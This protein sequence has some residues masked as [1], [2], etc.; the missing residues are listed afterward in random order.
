M[1]RMRSCCDLMMETIDQEFLVEQRIAEDFAYSVCSG[2]DW[3]TV[4]LEP[5]LQLRTLLIETGT[6]LLTALSHKPSSTTV[7]HALVF[8]IRCYNSV[9]DNP[10]GVPETIVS[11]GVIEA[12][13][14]VLEHV[15]Q[16]FTTD[17]SEVTDIRKQLNTDLIKILCR[18]TQQICGLS[19]TLLISTVSS[20]PHS[21]LHRVS[22]ISFMQI[23]ICVTNGT[24]NR[25]ITSSSPAAQVR[26]CEFSQLEM[27]SCILDSLGT[28]LQVTKR[29]DLVASPF[30]QSLCHWMLRMATPELVDSDTVLSGAETA[31][32]MTIMALHMPRQQLPL[33]SSLLSMF[34][35]MSS[36]VHILGRQQVVGFLAA[37]AK[38]T[39]Y[40]MNSAL[41]LI[42]TEIKQGLWDNM[43]SM[44]QASCL[45]NT[46]DLLILHNR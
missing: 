10:V 24:H 46:L 29:G 35:Q 21:F 27:H 17:L 31:R 37:A 9:W 32:I 16:T 23:S 20:L 34:A 25:A 15:L 28:M 22:A 43:D 30:M 12:L 44:A 42:G 7:H 45:F 26:S 14:S 6:R 18:F 2:Q 11:G 8:A 36:Q 38:N 3:R 40:N 33:P 13:N 4:P 1:K 41:L 39:R 5:Y 19:D